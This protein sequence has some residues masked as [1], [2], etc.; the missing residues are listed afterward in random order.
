MVGKQV[1]S[2]KKRD[3]ETGE[4]DPPCG[5]EDDNQ[6]GCEYQPENEGVH[7][8][9]LLTICLERGCAEL[10]LPNELCAAHRSN[11]CRAASDM[12]MLKHTG[13]E[14]S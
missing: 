4:H 13:L 7:V 12:V 3:G 8:F 10:V 11:L 5:L 2:G 14:G 9:T 6:R 1:R